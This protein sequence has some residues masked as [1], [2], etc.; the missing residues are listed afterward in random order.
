MLPLFVGLGAA[1][2][3]AASADPEPDTSPPTGP[4]TNASAYVYAG[5]RVGVQW[6]NGDSTAETEIARTTAALLQPTAREFV[7]PATETAYQTGQT[8][9]CYWWVRHRKNGQY[10]VWVIALHELGCT[11]D[12]D[13]GGILL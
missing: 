8:D 11:V 13:G 6:T 9:R 5:D 1:T 12:S 2:E 10:T 7:V 4:P 3:T